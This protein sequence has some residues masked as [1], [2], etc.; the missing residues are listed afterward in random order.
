[1]NCQNA[2][3]DFN[4]DHCMAAIQ[5]HTLLVSISQSPLYLEHQQN[6][7]TSICKPTYLVLQQSEFASGSQLK[8]ITEQVDN[9][10]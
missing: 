8:D 4:L 1:M 9:N 7:T 6:L 3:R 5:Y 10:T 2:I